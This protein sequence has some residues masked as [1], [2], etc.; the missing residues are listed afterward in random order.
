[1]ISLGGGGGIFN[2]PVPK[3][4]AR[5]EIETCADSPVQSGFPFPEYDTF[6]QK[7]ASITQKRIFD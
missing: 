6:L 2:L 5:T 1:M 3:F 7:L 4:G